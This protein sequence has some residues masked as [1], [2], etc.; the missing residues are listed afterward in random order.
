MISLAPRASLTFCFLFVLA[1]LHNRDFLSLSFCFLERRREGE[2]M[3][4]SADL[5]DACSGTVASAWAVG[6]VCLKP[7][8]G[9][10]IQL[11]CVSG[12]H[13]TT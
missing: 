6:L 2:N 11:S 9:N 4:L 7:E 12:R 10:T 13:P 5:L 3:L 8:A 1:F